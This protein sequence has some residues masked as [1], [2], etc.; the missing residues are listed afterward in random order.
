MEEGEEGSY[1]SSEK[2]L[3]FRALSHWRAVKAGRP[4]ETV[5]SPPKAA[6]EAR[7]CGYSCNRRQHHESMRLLHCPGPCR[8]WH[9]PKP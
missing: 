4:A 1:K 8:V 6:R 7:D 5:P 9:H 3:P 2:G